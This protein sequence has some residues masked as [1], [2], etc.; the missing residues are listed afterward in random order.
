MGNSTSLAAPADQAPLDAG[1]NDK[2]DRSYRN[3]FPDQ[4]SVGIGLTTKLE[5]TR[6]PKQI[7]QCSS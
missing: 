6:K 7:I 2:A 5:M 4:I 1:G 3:H